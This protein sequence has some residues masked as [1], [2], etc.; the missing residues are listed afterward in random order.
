MGI[1]AVIRDF[2]GNICVALATKLRG[3]FTT[4]VAECLAIR[5][6]P[7]F[8]IQHGFMVLVVESDPKNG[9]LSTQT[10]KTFS[11]KF[12]IISGI[13]VNL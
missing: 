3:H 2:N 8:A 4:H 13:L 1:G 11:M 9:V 5:E 7:H 10:H 6:G 12:P